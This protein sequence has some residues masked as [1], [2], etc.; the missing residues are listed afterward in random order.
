[1]VALGIEFDERSAAEFQRQMNRR[2]AW[3]RKTPEET[4]K[5]GAVLLAKSLGASTKVA[6]KLRP[7]VRNPD[8]RAKT[9]GR[10]AKFGVMKWRPDGTQ[11]FQPI[12]RT[13]EFGKIRF[14]DK[15]TARLVEYDPITRERR[16]VLWETGTG[17]FQIAGIA[18][19]KKRI[20]GR[21]GLARSAW[22]WVL[23]KL[24]S[25]T[26]AMQSEI[27]GSVRVSKRTLPEDY[28]VR[29]DNMLRYAMAALRRG[30]VDYRTALSRAANKMRL[31]TDRALK[32]IAA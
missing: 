15:K 19:S 13:V 30:R 12:Y 16:Y 22:S 1:M 23:N 32:K 31:Q 10:R 14:V 17:E 2:I 18:Q 24:G 26:H 29:M 20:I 25:M 8:P 6:P 5:Y 4:C 21:R 27:P 7:V 28:E 11:Y 9:D 3:L